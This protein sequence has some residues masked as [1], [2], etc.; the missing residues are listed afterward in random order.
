MGL[1][2]AL[3][4]F[5]GGIEERMVLCEGRFVFGEEEAKW[6]FIQRFKGRKAF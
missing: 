1:I 3:G 2:G 6:R 5:G 4:I